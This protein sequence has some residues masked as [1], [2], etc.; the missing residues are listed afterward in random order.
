MTTAGAT[1]RVRATATTAVGNMP[2][3][4]GS[5]ILGLLALYFI[6]FDEFVHDSRHF[7]GFP[8]H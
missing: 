8:C 7:L 5:L 1:A 2:Y 3:L 6:G 4:M